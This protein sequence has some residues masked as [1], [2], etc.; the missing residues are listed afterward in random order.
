MAAS[1]SFDI[2]SKVDLQEVQNAVQNCMREIAHRFDFKGSKSSVK[3]EEGRLVILCD[4]A[5]KLKQ[6]TDVL[7]QAMVK[8]NVPLRAMTYGKVEPAT[9][10]TVRQEVSLQSGIPTE[11]AKEIVKVIKNS[12]LK[13]QASIQDEQVRVT[14][15][16]R[17]DLQEVMKLLKGTELGIDM[18]FTNFR[19]G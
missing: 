9:G 10:S 7:R 5:E 15:K 17:D 16:S 12:K 8:R 6:L 1:N 14:G 11:K 3:L 13:V 4:D 18:Q 19:T 2:V